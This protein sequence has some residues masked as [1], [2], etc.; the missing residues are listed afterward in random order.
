MRSATSRLLALVALATSLL[1][2]LCS[3]PSQAQLI[4]LDRSYRVLKVDAD[5][6]VLEVG[7]A[8]TGARDADVII[9][10]ETRMYMF[11]KQIPS[12][13]WHLLRKGMKIR[14]HGGATWD[15]RVRAKK[16]FL[17]GGS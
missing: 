1:T 5:K 8:D 12:F 15:A 6:S 11:D 16:I 9:D 3:T 10:A 4:V 2:P 13:S 17:L 7:E 14:V